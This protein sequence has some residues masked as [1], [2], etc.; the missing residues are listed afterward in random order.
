MRL[1]VWRMFTQKAIENG[2]VIA[3]KDLSIKDTVDIRYNI[4]FER[5]IKSAILD[6]EKMGLKPIIYPLGYGSTMCNKQYW[7]D[8]KFDEALYLDKA[9]VKRKLEVAKQA[10]ENRKDLA[11]KMARPA[12]YRNIW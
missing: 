5:I 10:F 11:L 6:F 9:F 2:F 1:I 8:H 4:G 7:F 3:G 12:C